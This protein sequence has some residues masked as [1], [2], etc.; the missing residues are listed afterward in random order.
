MPLL[1]RP[2]CPACAN[3]ASKLSLTPANFARLLAALPAA[4]FLG[5][6]LPLQW[7]CPACRH[8]FLATGNQPH[9]ASPRPGFPVSPEKPSP[10]NNIDPT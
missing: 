2:R 3:P 9:N 10:P 1:H 6:F 7:R 5:D 8:S 4:L